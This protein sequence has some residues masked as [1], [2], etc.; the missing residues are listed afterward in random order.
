MDCR[1]KT[2]PDVLPVK[3]CQFAVRTT[4]GSPWTLDA[5]WLLSPAPPR[6]DIIESVGMDVDDIRRIIVRKS[7]SKS[8][9]DKLR[10]RDHHVAGSGVRA[11]VASRGQCQ[12]PFTRPQSAPASRLHPLSKEVTTNSGNLPAALNKLSSQDRSRH[13]TQGR[14]QR[15]ARRCQYTAFPKQQHVGRF[16]QEPEE[17]IQYT[18][19]ADG[20]AITTFS[21]PTAEEAH[22]APILE[23]I[24]SAEAGTICITDEILAEMQQLLAEAVPDANKPA[25]PL[26]D[27]DPSDVQQG[28][29]PEPGPEPEGPEEDL[30]GAAAC[31]QV[32]WSRLLANDQELPSAVV[33]GAGQSELP[34]ARSV[35]EPPPIAVSQVKVPTTLSRP[36]RPHPVYGLRSPTTRGSSVLRAGSRESLLARSAAGLR[37]MMNGCRDQGHQRKGSMHQLQEMRAAGAAPTVDWPHLLVSPQESSDVVLADAGN[38]ASSEAIPSSQ[39]RSDSKWSV[40]RWQQAG[41]S[42]ISALGK[43]CRPAS[44]LTSLPNSPSVSKTPV[45]QGATLLRSVTEPISRSG[46]RGS[47]KAASLL[48]AHGVRKRLTSIT[49]AEGIDLHHAPSRQSST[50]AESKQGDCRSESHASAY[51]QDGTDSHGGDD[52]IRATSK[53]GKAHMCNTGLISSDP[54]NLKNAFCHVAQGRGELNRAQLVWVLQ[55]LGYHH[56]DREL[57]EELSAENTSLSQAESFVSLYV[58]KDAENLKRQFQRADTNNS[59]TLG[60]GEMS[61]LLRR[62]GIVVRAGVV[63]ELMQ[64]TLEAVGNN[65]YHGVELDLD[66]VLVMDDHLNRS[67]GF[68]RAEAE[69]LQKVFIRYDRDEDG[70]ISRDELMAVVSWVGFKIDAKDIEPLLGKLDLD[71]SHHL[72]NS[73]FLLFMQQAKQMEIKHLTTVFGDTDRD[74]SGTT[75]AAELASIFEALGHTYASQEL[76]TEVRRQCGLADRSELLFED[77]LAIMEEARKTQ[78]YLQSE[79]QVVK[80]IFSLYDF[81]STEELG[82][83][84]ILKCMLHMGFS[85]SLD[86]VL[87]AFRELDFDKGGHLDFQEFVKLT[88]RHRNAEVLAVR[89]A[90]RA[91]REH[92]DGKVPFGELL[93]I[94]KTLEY[95]G[96]NTQDEYS[97]FVKQHC[98]GL[99][100][101]Q[102]G[103]WEFVRLICQFRSQ[104]GSVAVANMFFNDIE[105]AQIR[106][107]FRKC[108]KAR[109]RGVPTDHLPLLL[110]GLLPACRHKESM[111]AALLVEA[112]RPDSNIQ[113]Q[114][115][116]HHVRRAYDQV[117]RQRL[118]KDRLAM[119]KVQFA[120]AEVREFRRIYNT[121]D[122]EETGDV[123]VTA[124][125]EWMYEIIAADIPMQQFEQS[126]ADSVKDVIENETAH[127]D[128]AEFILAMQALLEKNWRDINRYMI[129]GSP[130]LP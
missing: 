117:D 25:A 40:L 41:V 83:V 17:T 57:V 48:L 105:L 81:S 36:S 70:K 13:K 11:V 55:L 16:G 4:Q 122:R 107:R 124:F 6:S 61:W 114:D 93:P 24:P 88:S 65:F 111:V 110:E 22:N 79:L 108:E 89:T 14:K 74:N 99:E 68:S 20:K 44:A 7:A 125:A 35:I 75:D 69:R 63:E 2:K 34:S 62:H 104:R 39:T 31:L 5:G 50:Q 49:N 43:S 78:G 19:A 127:M 53:L 73:Y 121:F 90:F 97:K 123:S 56:P 60:V 95:V 103:L 8:L 76:I 82:P 87:E 54:D 67:A 66:Q 12:E 27:G 26:V 118:E 46:G 85:A 32:D 15:S 109:N 38:S 80:D 23:A 30:N 84:D 37:P 101:Q 106:K 1:A 10:T 29:N 96:V 130:R 91:R 120:D 92:F 112:G 77:V 45:A 21:K 28:S 115:C 98:K 3:S 128:F 129:G 72:S 113:V 59:G 64:D 52:G 47:A 86:D 102:L 94:L 126:L 58:T 18:P 51:N 42:V 100:D 71:A 9:S 119:Q 33:A 116:V